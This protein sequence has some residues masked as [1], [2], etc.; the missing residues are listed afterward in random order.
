MPSPS[1]LS[2]ISSR[3][4]PSADLHASDS[5]FSPRARLLPKPPP[6]PPP[7]LHIMAAGTAIAFWCLAGLA[8]CAPPGQ[9]AGAAHM[10]GTGAGAAPQR[11]DEASKCSPEPLGRCVPHSV[12]PWGSCGRRVAEVQGKRG[13][14]VSEQ[15]LTA[16]WG[17]QGRTGVVSCRKHTAG[18]AFSQSAT[19]DQAL[20]QRHSSRP[21]PSS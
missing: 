3:H 17:R 12:R 13:D 14:G 5:I 19:Q 20:L 10:D 18:A 4:P 11:G 2:K 9:R 7:P 6:S 1:V 21:S 16:T 8:Q 15:G